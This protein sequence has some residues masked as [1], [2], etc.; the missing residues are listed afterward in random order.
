MRRVY[1]VA[2]ISISYQLTSCHLEITCHPVHDM[3]GFGMDCRIVERILCV[4][5]PEKACTLLEGLF[6]QSLHLEKLGT[7]GV[8]SVLGAI[9]HNVISKSRA[10]ARNIAQEIAAGCVKVHSHAVHTA[11]HRVVQFLLEKSLIDVMLVLAHSERLR[12]YLH[13]FC[14]RVHE[15]ATDGYRS[16]YGHVIVRK[17][18][19]SDL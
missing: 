15:T 11:L 8:G 9:V 14:K 6:P 17:L 1:P 4:G 18:F 3:I 12:I 19:T 13:K 10:D 2:K 7:G 16:T 5:D